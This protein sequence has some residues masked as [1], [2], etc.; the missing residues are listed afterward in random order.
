MEI[1]ATIWQFLLWNSLIN[2]QTDHLKACNNSRP[3]TPAITKELQVRCQ[4]LKERETGKEK[5]W[6]RE[7]NWAFS[8]L[9][10]T[11]TLTL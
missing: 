3:W 8:G 1:R 4:H 9:H 5:A 11:I 7:G 2:E 6:D 10:K